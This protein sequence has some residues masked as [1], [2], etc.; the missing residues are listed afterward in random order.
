MSCLWY[1]QTNWNFLRTFLIQSLNRKI[2][3]M[4]IFLLWERKTF[5][6]PSHARVFLDHSLRPPAPLFPLSSFHGVWPG[7]QPRAGGLLGCFLTHRADSRGLNP[8]HKFSCYKEGMQ[9]EL[10]AAQRTEWEVRRSFKA[11]FSSL[12][13]LLI[14]S[15]FWRNSYGPNWTAGCCCQ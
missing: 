1:A 11:V 15:R 2:M 10:R 5:L 13:L 14:D 9:W 3:F 7:Q 12:P 6:V 4:I 8:C